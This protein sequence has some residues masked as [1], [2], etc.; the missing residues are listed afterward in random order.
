ME[1]EVDRGKKWYNEVSMAQVLIIED[2]KFLSKI[3]STKL[4]NEGIDAEFAVDGEMGL[5]M[6]RGARPKL[7]LLDLIM[8]KLDGFG[9]LEAMSADSDLNTIPV[10]V[11]SNLGQDEDM[12][13]AKELGAKDFIVKSDT[14]IGDVIDKIKAEL[15]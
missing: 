14:S 3:Y 7:I 1:A 13:R 15:A 11:L 10:Y 9:V 5:E 6:M 8:P 2:D 12:A 4:K